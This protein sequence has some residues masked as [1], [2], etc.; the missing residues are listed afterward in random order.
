M[1]L[2]CQAGERQ[3]EWRKN[4]FFG[5]NM[6]IRRMAVLNRPLGKNLR[7][8]VFSNG[9]LTHLR[10]GNGQFLLDYVNMVADARLSI[11][12]IINAQGA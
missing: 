10:F 8:G 12:T 2:R 1:P 6:R 11:A 3:S 5:P 4:Q 9:R 7:S